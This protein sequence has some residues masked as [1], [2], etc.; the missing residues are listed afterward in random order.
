MLFS[1]STLE[2]FSAEI[3][4][5]AV[6]QLLG[7]L[8]KH[9]DLV[10][11]RFKEQ[12]ISIAVTSFA[13]RFKHGLPGAFFTQAIAEGRKRAEPGMKTLGDA[14]MID[15]EFL[16]P[17]ITASYAHLTFR[18]G[19]LVLQRVGDKNVHPFTHMFL[20]FLQ[21][22]LSMPRAM[23]LIENYELWTEICSFLSALAKS[24]K[25]DPMTE[26]PAFLQPDKGVGQPLTEDF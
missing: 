23:A 11:T 7:V 12:G 21:S 8:D 2:S 15:D 18:I 22:L 1:H 14:A 6:N 10:N 16:A 3:F 5:E 25:F 24:K 9:I 13:A 20:V 19:K 17:S 26:N 4:Y